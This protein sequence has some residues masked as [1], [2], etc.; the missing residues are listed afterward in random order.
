[1]AQVENHLYHLACHRKSPPG[2]QSCV[3]RRLAISQMTPH[4]MRSGELSKNG[5]RASRKTVFH[6]TFHTRSNTFDDRLCGINHALWKW[7]RLPKGCCLSQCLHHIIE[8][9]EERP[10]LNGISADEEGQGFGVCSRESHKRARDDGM[11]SQTALSCHS[12]KKCGRKS[13][14]WRVHTLDFW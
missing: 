9:K 12:E 13:P 8:G 1:M 10:G 7:G 11:S 4:F 5:Q 3:S 14:S 2:K 6:S